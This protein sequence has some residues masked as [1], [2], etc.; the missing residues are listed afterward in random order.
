MDVHTPE[1]RSRNMAAIRGK[2]TGPE[3]TVRSLVHGLGFRFRLH[4]KDLPGTPDMVFRSARKVIFVHGCFWHRHDCPLGSVQCRSNAEFW[5][6]KFESNVRR[7][8][9]NLDELRALGW[10]A[11]IVWECWLKNP[12][13]TRRRVMAFLQ[14]QSG[15]AVRIRRQA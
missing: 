12:A 8:R 4:A 9:R 11:L 6:R 2:D 1:Q 3:R 13:A 10:D 14:R 15:G 5:Q 7:D